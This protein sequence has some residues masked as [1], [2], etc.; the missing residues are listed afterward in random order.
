MGFE[1]G[2]KAAKAAA[3]QPIMIGF[4]IFKCLWNHFIKTLLV[5]GSGEVQ[6]LKQLSNGQKLSDFGFSSVYGILS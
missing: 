5:G 2:C 3:K 1:G 6:Q 4:W